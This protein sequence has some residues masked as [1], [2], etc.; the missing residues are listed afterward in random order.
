M[1]MTSL[2]DILMMAAVAIG[3]GRLPQQWRSDGLLIASLTGLFWLQNDWVVSFATLLIVLLVWRVTQAEPLNPRTPL[4]HNT[5]HPPTPSPSSLRSERRGEG[6]RGLGWAGY[7]VSYRTLTTGGMG[8]GI[9]M[10]VSRPASLPNVVESSAVMLL[11]AGLV[12]TGEQYL[13][14]TPRR[15]MNAV[16]VASLIGLLVVFK[17][18]GLVWLG[19]SY[20]IFRLLA[21]LLDPQPLPAAALPDT[22][23]FAIFPPALPAGPIDRVQHF[24]PQIHHSTPVETSRLLRG[25]QR[26]ADGLVRKFVL[27]DSLALITLS[28]QLAGDVESMGGAWLLAYAY[29]FQ[30]FL[31][32]SGYTSVAIGL[33]L[34]AGLELPENFNR[35]YLQPNLALF[36]QNWHMTLTGWFRTYCFLPLSRALLRR[37]LPIS[38]YLIAQGVTMSLI[39]LWHGIEGHFLLWGLWHTLGLYVYHVTSRWTR[40]WYLAR[41]ERAQYLIRLGGWLLTFHYVVVG[42]VFFALPEPLPFLGKLVGL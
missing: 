5:P 11:L 19:L 36:W 21:M 14:T 38:E 2:T 22:I 37:R 28:P 24:V 30:I 27:A 31:D 29:A 34:L 10:M 33:A 1:S 35:P 41:S 23:T 40:G 39:A 7:N 42:W 9:G 3:V 4:T 32:F 8:I 15:A 25:G 13:A 26:I 6:F 18:A 17:A 12:I 16:L 20:M